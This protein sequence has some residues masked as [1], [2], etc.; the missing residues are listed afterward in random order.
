[1]TPAVLMVK[2]AANGQQ[3]R[4]LMQAGLTQQ[5]AFRSDVVL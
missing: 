1:M 5:S 4:K 2:T 3:V